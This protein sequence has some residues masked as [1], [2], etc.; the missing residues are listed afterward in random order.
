VALSYRHLTWVFPLLNLA[1]AIGAQIALPRLLQLELSP[2]EYAAYIAVTS[3]AAYV[4]LADGGLRLPILREMTVAH[5]SN[6][7]GAFLG[8]GRRAARVYTLVGLVGASVALLVLPTTLGVVRRGWEGAA[9][10]AFIVACV[11]MVVSSAVA[12]SAGVTHGSFLYSTGRLLAGAAVTLACTILSIIVL[13]G[14]LA[15]TRDLVWGISAS[16]ASG[17]LIA[18]LR[19]AAARREYLRSRRTSRVGSPK[20]RLRDLMSDGLALK[21]ADVLQQAAFPH[22]YTLVAFHI[23]PVGIPCR[24]LANACRMLSQQFL[25]L[26]A[27]H[28]TRRHATTDE[29]RQLGQRE[30]T[31]TSLVLCGAHVAQ[32]AVVTLLAERVFALWLPPIASQVRAFLPGM[33]VEQ[34][35]LSATLPSS[36]MFMA[37]GR[38]RAWGIAQTCGAVL[39]LGTM[40]AVVRVNPEA[41]LGFGLGVAAVPPFVLAASIE[42]LQRG[43]N[44]QADSAVVL[45]YGLAVVTAVLLGASGFRP[46][47]YPLLALALGTLVFAVGTIGFLRYLRLR[48]VT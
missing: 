3:V 37:T 2:Q 10:T 23:V 43:S 22:V 16:A 5:A 14:V 28:M 33:L 35:L 39:G 8:E 29:T 36:M 32:A 38:L 34:A 46:V 24:T 15:V 42:F 20:R 26:L 27:V 17:L 45:R 13:L 12:F 44:A 1:T 9:S 48:N 6:D 31:V 40:V 7:P 19:A 25:N 41:A 11:A 30:Y 4:G 18:T 21:S 47:L